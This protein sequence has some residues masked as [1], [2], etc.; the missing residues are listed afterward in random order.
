MSARV[1]RSRSRSPRSHS[2]KIKLI[3][4]RSCDISADETM[5]LV[6]TWGVE[7]IKVSDLTQDAEGDQVLKIIGRSQTVVFNAF[8]EVSCRQC[9]G[10]FVF[11]RGDG[12]EARILI[13]ESLTSKLTRK[14]LDEV[15]DLSQASISLQ[16]AI[17]GRREVPLRVSGKLSAVESAFE[18]ITNTLAEQAQAEKTE[19]PAAKFVVPKSLITQLPSDFLIRCREDNG[20]EVTTVESDGPPCLDTE[21]IIVCPMQ[22]LKGKLANFKQAIRLLV[23]QLAELQESASLDDQLKMLVPSNQ[24]RKLI[25]QGGTMIKEIQNKTGGANIKVVSEKNNERQL[26]TIVTIQGT[27]ESKVEACRIIMEKLESFKTGGS[28][29]P[30]QDFGRDGHEHRMSPRNSRLSINVTVPDSHVCRLIGRKGET[31]NNLKRKSGCKFEFEKTPCTEVLTGNNENTRICKLS[32]SLDEVQEGLKL[33][34]E[35]V[36]QLESQ[37]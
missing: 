30:L 29:S 2:F 5:G 31:I 27:R 35:Q 18:V 22:V 11:G 13:P 8:T 28:S 12:S 24:V 26:N 19:T 6:E 23:N 20:V 17:P 36:I 34:L 10:K 1:S 14:K 7:R 4:P 37:H 33:L 15:Q 21:A 16:G 3:L 25:G 32:G 9:L